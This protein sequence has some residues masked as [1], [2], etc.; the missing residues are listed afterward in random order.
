MA[1]SAEVHRT[2]TKSERQGAVNVISLGIAIVLALF[3]G[4]LNTHTDELLVLVPWMV[5]ATAALGVA[6]PRQPWLWALLIGIAV[7]GS[8]VLFYLLQLRV[9]YPNNPGDIGTS[10]V[11]FVPAFVGAYVGAGVRRLTAPGTPST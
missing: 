6:Q 8:L 2:I 10:F 1:E 7:P 11:V 4:Y 9:P 3:T 5:V